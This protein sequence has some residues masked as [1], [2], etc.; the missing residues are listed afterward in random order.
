MGFKKTSGGAFQN[1][2]EFCSGRVRLGG[3]WQ[4]DWSTL[5]DGGLTKGKMEEGQAGKGA[6]HDGVGE[7]AADD[8]LDVK[9]S[10]R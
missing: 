10:V 7:R 3:V 5:D 6:M 4:V 1:V 9:K 2:E 8:A